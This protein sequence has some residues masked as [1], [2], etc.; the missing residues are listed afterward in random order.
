M[1]RRTHPTGPRELEARRTNQQRPARAR[2]SRRTKTQQRPPPP[3]SERARRHHP[4]RA[5]AESVKR[6]GEKRTHPTAPRGS[7]RASAPQPKAA[8]E[9]ARR[10]TQKA[11]ARSERGDAPN[12]QRP[13][14][15]EGRDAPHHQQRP[16]RGRARRTHP[17]AGPAR[18]RG[19]RRTTQQRPARA[20][21]ERARR[22]HNS[23]LREREGE[24]HPPKRARGSER[25]SITHTTATRDREGEYATTHKSGPRAEIERDAP[26]PNSWPAS[27][28]AR[29][30]NH[31][32]TRRARE[33]RCFVEREGETHPPN[34]ARPEREGEEAPT[35]PAAC[36]RRERDEPT[37]Q[38]PG[39]REGETPSLA[40]QRPA[41]ARGREAPT[42]PPK[43]SGPR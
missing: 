4:T 17:T 28:R 1:A 34:S 18:A 14:E 35:K 30:P 37:Q 11:P 9:R 41:R 10:T 26:T 36:E 20:R 31:T 5:H 2:E 38:R 40:S 8:R 42:Q 22:T 43:N 39:E 23:R 16:S 32:R 33:A 24:K 7:E 6:E 13:G 29:R 19:A 3:R 12:Q 15:R 21:A 27:E 25:A